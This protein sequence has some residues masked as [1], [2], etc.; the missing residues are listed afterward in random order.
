MANVNYDLQKRER[1]RAKQAKKVAKARDKIAPEE[2]PISEPDPIPDF[3]N[4]RDE[5]GS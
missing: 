3:D 5:A 1:E 4:K 2:R